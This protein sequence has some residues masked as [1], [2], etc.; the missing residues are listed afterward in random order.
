MENNFEITEEF[1]EKLESEYDIYAA[2]CGAAMQ[3]AL[4]KIKILSDAYNQVGKRN[5]F[6]RIESRIKTFKSVRGKCRDRGYDLTMPSIKEHIKD[7]GGIRIITKYL[8]E[9]NLVKDMIMQIPEINI[10]SVKDYITTPKESGY[11][12]IHLSCQVGVYDPFQG[13]R[14]RPLEIQI[15]TK[16]MNLWATLEHDIN[17]KSPFHVKEVDERFLHIAEI[18]R[19][20]EDEAMALRDICELI[21]GVPE[22]EGEALDVLKLH[23]VSQNKTDQNSTDN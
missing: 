1:L 20:L 13:L 11:S 12:S 17:Y 5:P 2:E 15:R 3:T 9:V 7:V 6:D 21:K 22:T 23:Q 18:L 4:I 16:S 19:Q 8:D 14:M 10:I